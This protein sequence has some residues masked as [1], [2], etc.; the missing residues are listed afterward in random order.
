MEPV[1][2]IATFTKDGIFPRVIKWGQRRYRILQVN[3]AHSIKDGAV[4]VYFF[5]VSDG[6]NAWKLGF[7]TETLKWWVEDFY[8][9][10]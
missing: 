6:A 2:V 8:T 10:N 4:R 7:N 5:S 9:V 3:L 1:D